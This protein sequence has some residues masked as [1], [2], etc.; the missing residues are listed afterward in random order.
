MLY[1]VRILLL[2]L[3]VAVLVVVTVTAPGKATDGSDRIGTAGRPLDDLSGVMDQSMTRDVRR[4][5]TMATYLL[6]LVTES[7]R[8]SIASCCL[9]RFNVGSERKEFLLYIMVKI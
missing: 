1:P 6:Y 5:N 3:R 7:Y 4:A 8:S 9:Y 2:M